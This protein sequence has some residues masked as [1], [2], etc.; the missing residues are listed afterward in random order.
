MSAIILFIFPS[1]EFGGHFLLRFLQGKYKSLHLT[2]FQLRMFKSGH[3]NAAVFSIIAL[4]SQLLIDHTGYAETLTWFLRAGFVALTVLISAGF[5]FGAMGEGRTTSNNWISL[6]F[7]A[8]VL[9]STCMFAHGIGL[10]E[11][12]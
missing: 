10:L 7:V 4:I 3:S 8:T 2:L 6:V 5:F 12:C 11:T 9:V 1:I